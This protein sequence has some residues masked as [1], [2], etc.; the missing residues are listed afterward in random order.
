MNQSRFINR[1]CGLFRGQA[2]DDTQPNELRDELKFIRERDARK[3]VENIKGKLR[4]LHQSVTTPPAANEHFWE[5]MDPPPF[6][7]DALYRGERAKNRIAGLFDN[8]NRDTKQSKETILDNTGK[9]RKNLEKARS[10]L[11]PFKK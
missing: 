9:I 2:Q 3:F 8:F 1:L 11:P 10:H 7:Q 4:S 6:E 5:K